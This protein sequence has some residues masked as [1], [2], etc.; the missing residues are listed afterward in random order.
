MGSEKKE[1]LEELR[2]QYP[3]SFKRWLTRE[4]ESGRMSNKEAIMRFSI[5]PRTLLDWLNSYSL[6]KELS[7]SIMTPEEKQEKALLEKRIRELE[8][9]LEY[10]KL[11]NI[12]IET[13]IDVAEKQLNISIRKKA[14][15]KQ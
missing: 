7:L 15:P 1:E 6:G 3:V 12:A 5:N 4:I 8:K 9:A 11:K 10:A 14:G 13:M 2:E